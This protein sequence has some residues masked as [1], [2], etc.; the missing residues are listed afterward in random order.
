MYDSKIL[1][2]QVF[3]RQ[4]TQG[5]RSHLPIFSPGSICSLLL[6]TKGSGSGKWRARPRQRT[7][8][9]G[10]MGACECLTRARRAQIEYLPQRPGK[11]GYPSGPVAALPKGDPYPSSPKVGLRLPHLHKQF[12]PLLLPTRERNNCHGDNVFKVHSPPQ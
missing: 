8:L 11:L 10:W 1:W 6:T 5:T 2:S 9:P 12:P 7:P 3:R 4:N